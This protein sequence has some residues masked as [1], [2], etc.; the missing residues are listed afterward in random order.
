MGLA[1]RYFPYNMAAQM[2]LTAEPRALVQRHYRP[3]SLHWCQIF[4]SLIERKLMGLL[5]R[6]VVG[7]DLRCSGDIA[8]QS[9]F[10]LA[11]RCTGGHDIAPNIVIGA[12]STAGST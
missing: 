8:L 3:A 10:E 9:A 1:K 11:M 12:S 5:K 4:H 6:I 2:F 7:H